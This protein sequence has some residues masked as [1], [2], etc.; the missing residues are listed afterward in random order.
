MEANIPPKFSDEACDLV[1][2]LATMFIA[3]IFILAGITKLMDSADFETSL[4]RMEVFPDWT[5]ALLVTVIPLVEIALG[6][7]CLVT[8]PARFALQGLLA[9]TAL[10][11]L[12]LSYE[13]LRGIEVGCACFGPKSAHWPQW[14][15]ILRNLGLLLL[16]ICLLNSDWLRPAK[17]GD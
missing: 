15:L 4:I 10:Y 12:L 13:W 6:L 2:R 5:L 7:L 11:T 9:L 16:E 3:L 14:A 1:V 17:A 8:S